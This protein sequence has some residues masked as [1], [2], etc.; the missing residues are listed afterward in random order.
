M[1]RATQLALSRINQRFYAR[2]AGQWSDKRKHAWPGFEQVWQRCLAAIGSGCPDAHV[3]DVGCGDG[4]FARF[5]SER[6]VTPLCY[7]GVDNSP[8]LLAHAAERALPPSFRFQ[9]LDFVSSPIADQLGAERFQLIAL[10]GVLHHVPGSARRAVL[11]RTLAQ[12]LAPE[13]HLVFTIWR[14]DEDP[15]FASRKIPFAD[16]NRG[17]AEPVDLDQLE[18]GDH[19]LRWDDQTD[20]PR[21]CHFPDSAQL[22]QL[23]AETGLEEIARF[24]ADGHLKRMNEYV[25]LRAHR[26]Y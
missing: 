19:L 16:Y 18:P 21:Y 5:L 24:R 13:G 3:L 4:R 6:A 22:S 23:I 7:L 17:A 10:F 14:L 9:Q 11:L 20:T 25:V 8:A 26:R 12:L 2:I 1:D 15:R